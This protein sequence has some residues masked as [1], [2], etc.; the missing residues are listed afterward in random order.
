MLKPFFAD[1]HVH[2]G[3][4]RDGRPIKISASKNLTIE[5][6]LIEASRKKGIELIGVIDAHVPTVI[7]ELEKM[8][9]E[10]IAFERKAG[11]IVF[12]DVTVL[13]GSEIEIYDQYA[14]GPIHVLAFMPNIETMKQFSNYL[15]QFIKN[16][17]LSSQRFHG[18]GYQLQRK[19]KELGGLFIPAHVFTPFKSLYG[20][21]V[22]TTLAEVF[23]PKKIDAIE[24]GL[25]SDT[26]MAD[27][28]AEL[29]VYPFL[30]NSDSHS[31]AKIGREYNKLL[32]KEPSFIELINAL[33]NEKGRKI[34]ANYGLNP[35]LGKYYRTVCR[36]CSETIQTPSST[37][38]YC[39][40][41][42]VIKGVRDRILEL[43]TENNK[44]QARPPYIYQVPLEFIPGLGKKTLQKLIK[45]FQ[46]EMNIIHNVTYKELVEVVSPEIAKMILELRKGELTIVAGG[47]GKYGYISLTND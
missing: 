31:L 13:L 25:S 27:Q 37:C 35:K 11:G 16:I 21:G 26:T 2:L 30:T 33:R 14:S 20:K 29:N 10:K 24:L 12:E 43:K 28:I 17:Q 7:D 8:I 4:D 40:S 38:P 39:N 45:A 44:T 19:I 42:N 46:T 36:S 1:L 32:L 41:S 15:S 23:D 34:I 22:K 18:E 47:G 9:I 3:Q 5:N 6:I